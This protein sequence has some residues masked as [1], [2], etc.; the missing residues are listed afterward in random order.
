MKLQRQ[1]SSYSIGDEEFL[2]ITPFL[3]KDRL[4]GADARLSE[5]PNASESLQTESADSA[6]VELME[7]LSSLRDASNL[8][9]RPGEET[10]SV[11][12]ANVDTQSRRISSRPGV[13]LPPF[14]FLGD[15]DPR[16]KNYNC[17]IL[18][19]CLS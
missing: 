12:F 11:Y 19:S 1:I 17:S 8:D 10:E 9:T 4:Q 6:W 15:L 7:D 2:V 18:K 5:N 16:R 13:R 3:K 14:S